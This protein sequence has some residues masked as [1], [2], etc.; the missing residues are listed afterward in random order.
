MGR[1]VG[2]D[3]GTTNT[4]VAVLQD[5]RPRVIE[6]DRG[7]KVL[8]SV[9]SARGEGRYIVGQA[10]HNL[11]L[12]HP[13]RTVYATKRLIGRRFESPEVQ[14]AAERMQYE[15]RA[16]EDGL[17][18]VKVGDQWMTPAEVAAV[19]LQVARNIA[20][21]ALGEP[22]DG[23]V[24][25]VP[26]HFNHLQREQTMLAA[27]LAGLHCDR[28]LNE[29]TAAALAY[30][31]R[32]SVDR[33]VV[34]FDLGG[35]TFD[36]SVLKLTEGVYEILSTSGDTFLGGEDFDYRV[37]DH[38]ADHFQ[39]RTMQDVREDRNALQRLK[40]AAER[41][42]CD[43]SFSDRTNVVV[44]HITPKENLEM[45]LTRT[46]LESLTGD[47]IQR[48]VDVTRQSV[49][50]AGLQ[51]A[52]VEEVILVGG[53]TRM[54][55]IREA[56]SGLFGREPSR[57][58]HPEEAVAV[59]AAVHAASLSDPASPATTL[60]DVTPFDLGIDAVG[61]LF[62]PV[63]ARNSRV[64]SQESRTFATVH[65]EQTTV[66]VT[67]R[68]GESR[69]ASENEFLGEFVMDGLQ[70]L[71]KLQNKVDIAF[72]IDAN[73]MLHVT[74][75]E[76]ATGEK[77][78]LTVKNFVER[79][80]A[81][82]LPT[83]DEAAADRQARERRADVAQG[84]AAA[85]GVARKVGLFASLFGAR[86]GA[87]AA[88]PA[89]RAPRPAPGA[90]APVE[91]AE[92][93]MAPPPE[94]DLATVPVDAVMPDEAIVEFT[95]PPGTAVPLLN[96]LDD[97]DV[98][99]HDQTPAAFGLAGTQEAAGSAATGDDPFA[100]VADP[101]LDASDLFGEAVL[102]GD[103]DPATDRGR[104]ASDSW[105]DPF[106]RAG[107]PGLDESGESAFAMPDEAPASEQS[108]ITFEGMVEP[109]PAD[110]G[111]GFGF[112]LPPPAAAPASP[113]ART[114]PAAAKKKKP[115]RLKL[116]Y[117]ERE[118]FLAEYRE[119]M[120]QNGAFIR[121][122]KPLAIGRECVFEVDAPG[123]PEPLIFGAVVAY[124]N[125]GANGEPPGMGVD[126]TLEP[127]EKARIERLLDRL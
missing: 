126:Y 70:P 36:V 33:T 50:D 39:A 115:A 123:L 26:A 90:A 100:G 88:A 49:A 21:K 65:D 64:P 28:L 30:G 32:K 54:P 10:A 79:A 97:D 5:G 9:V 78:N 85:P 102:D 116:H 81:P 37:V 44:A 112:A 15:V 122:E 58:V 86:K 89:P 47:L 14:K 23:A 118:A 6:D 46:T 7:Y 109:E 127:G 105:A 27:Q 119:N 31:H 20:E 84:A 76:R 56:V 108:G 25:T 45:V 51:L 73:G 83:P 18:Q 19:V 1:I 103:D 67:V 96:A 16:G 53:Q 80:Q 41:A 110:F 95:S 52:D 8:P 75:T 99:G 77:R 57:S 82:H 3:L 106:A 92:P 125:S 22:V 107:E 34:I 71:P 124:T 111:G 35:G 38:L 55:K 120:R 74:A 24:I 60:L 93:T 29:P 40:D 68:Q 12:T 11:I 66:R 13:D 87:K 63:I 48:C 43:L 91:R 42:K 61:G 59:G 72:R 62:T 98:Y 69:V 101:G 94:I 4:A 117:H 121:T 114:E 104:T 2:I 113:A 17:V